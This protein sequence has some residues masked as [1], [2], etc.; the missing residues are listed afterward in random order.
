MRLRVARAV[1]AERHEDPMA[2]LISLNVGLPRDVSWRGETVYTAIWKQP[3]QGGRTVRRLNIEGD[4]QGDLAGHG[5]V[6]RAVM[7][8]QLDSYRYWEQQLGRSDFTYGQFGENFTVDGL[9]DDT[10]CVGD[11][12]RIGSALFEVSQPRVTCYRFGIRMN[13][14]K[15]PSLVVSHHRPGF[16]LRV[17][18][19]GLVAAGDEIVKIAGGPEAM[20]IAEIDALLYLP[21]HPTETLQ[22]ALRVAPLSAGWRQSFQDLL[23][24]AQPPA[25]AWSGFRQL[26]VARV[27]EESLSVRSF[28]LENPDG[29]K[30]PPPRPGQFLVVRINRAGAAPILRS[31]SLSGD[32]RS[33]VYRISVKRENDGVGSG[34]LHHNVHEGGV[35]EV[36]APTGNFTLSSTDDPAVLI[37]AG[38]G[39][40]PVLAMLHALASERSAREVWWLYGARS[41][42]EHPFAKEADALLQTIERHRSFIMYSRPESGDQPGTAFDARGHLGVS[43]LRELNVPQQS[44]FYLCGPASFLSEMTAALHDYGVPADRIRSEIFGMGEALKPG[45]KSGPVKQPH[46]PSGAAGTGPTIAFT[47]SGISV[48]WGD[49]FHSLLELAEA[50]DVPARWACRTGVCHNCE[51]ALIGG[52]VEYDP[53]PLEPPQ[54][55]NLL[56]CCSRPRSEVQIDL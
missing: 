36:S 38:I 10:V 14:P 53:D 45:I 41:G 30:L 11:R 3:V 50:C 9:S 40:T 52:E 6:N 46:A 17:L 29:S 8:Y 32:P 2:R 26:R 31:Y 15:M 43:T 27:E 5:G 33:G 25:P 51:C 18:E 34:F 4:G 54:K 49:R 20:S 55:G 47:R 24:T 12:Y 7:V 23:D 16:Y 37:S 28:Y 56:L 19:E 48:P 22:R 44:E 1:S 35:L 21:G 13:E 42:R 39:A